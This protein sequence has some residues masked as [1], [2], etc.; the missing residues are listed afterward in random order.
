M[1]GDL[2]SHLKDPKI[3]YNEGM[4]KSIMKQIMTGLKYMHSAGFVHRDLKPQ[5]LLILDRGTDLGNDRFQ[6]KLCDFGLA[7]NIT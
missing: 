5:N 4:L 1:D 2:N 7:R 6:C 3:K